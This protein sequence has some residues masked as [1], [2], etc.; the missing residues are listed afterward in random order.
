MMTPDTG[1]HWSDVPFNKY[2]RILCVDI[3]LF[4][5]FSMRRLFVIA[6]N[7]TFIHKGKAV[8]ACQVG[9]ELGVRYV[10][11]GSVRKA[12]NR[13]PIG[14]QLVDALARDRLSSCSWRSR[15]ALLVAGPDWQAGGRGLP[16]RLRQS[17]SFREFR[18]C[19]YVGLLTHG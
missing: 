2:R 1:K 11:E 16:T 4:R 12:A 8:D 18:I 3:S 9:Q 5:S 17:V 14:G 10:L 6:R 7:S 13:V 15:G 19:R